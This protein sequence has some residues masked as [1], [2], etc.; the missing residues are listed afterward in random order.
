MLNGCRTPSIHPC[1]T[2]CS[3]QAI[4]LPMSWWSLQTYE[5]EICEW[6][7]H[8]AEATDQGRSHLEESLRLLMAWRLQI[9]QSASYRPSGSCFSTWGS[10]RSNCVVTGGRQR[11][12]FTTESPTSYRCDNYHSLPIIH[13]PI[14]LTTLSL[15]RG[16]GL[17]SNIQLVSI[18]CP[19]KRM[20][21]VK[22][23]DD[24]AVAIRRNS[25]NIC[26][27]CICSCNDIVGGGA[28]N[29]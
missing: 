14:L 23:H 25:S 26:Q 1:T 24:L 7:A 29:I 12:P 2:P 17:Y 13:P 11:V 21:A 10:T 4:V 20:N 6:K 9:G 19:H 8:S 22:S 16:G 15:Q 28:W 3:S 18:I 27:C 5:T